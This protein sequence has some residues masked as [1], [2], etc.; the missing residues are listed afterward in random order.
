MRGGYSES[1]GSGASMP[2]ALPR[3]LPRLAVAARPRRPSVMKRPLSLVNTL[4]QLTASSASR[5]RGVAVERQAEVVVD[6]LVG[7]SCARP[8]PRTCGS[9]RSRAGTA[10][11]RARRRAASPR[12]AARPRAGRTA[13]DSRCSSARRRAGCRCRGTPRPRSAPACGG[14][15]PSA[16]SSQIAICARGAGVNCELEHRA[17]HRPARAPD[18]PPATHARS[19]ARAATRARDLHGRSSVAS[20]HS[21]PTI[22]RPRRTRSVTRAR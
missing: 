19:A 4:A 22:A 2:R 1:S 21:E 18:A 11:R 20:R 3:V 12:S 8:A 5:V 13:S 16:R 14:S 6:R 9:G 15:V 10:A 7:A 17:G